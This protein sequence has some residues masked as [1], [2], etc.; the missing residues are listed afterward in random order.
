MTFSA[1]GP[2]HWR[3]Y[4]P[5]AVALWAIAAANAAGPVWAAILGGTDQDYAAAVAADPQGNVYVAGLTSSPDFLVTPGALQTKIGGSSDAFVAKF[6]PDGVLLWSTYLGGISDD[7]ATGVAVDAAGNVLV[8]GWTRSANFPILHAVQATLNNGASLNRQ[9]AFVAKLDPTGAKLLYATFLGGSGDDGAY[10]LALDAAGNAYVTGNVQ[11]SASFP[12]LKSLPDVS[13][14][15][16][17]KLDPQGAL[18]YTFLHPYG[19]ATG[20]AVDAA[21]SAYVAGTV[22]SNAPANS[23]TQT[24]GVPGDARAM[25]FKLS[26]DGSRRIYETTLGG[27][28]RADGMAVAVDRT[29]AALLAGTTSSAD[30]PLV[31]SLQSSLGARPLWKSTD[32][33]ATWVPLDDLPFANLQT[34]VVDPT[35]PNTLYAAAGDGGIFKSVDGGVTWKP[36]S[37]GIATTHMRAL[38]I[39][40]LHPQVLYAATGAGVSTGLV[41][42]T[43]DGGNNW[44]AVESMPSA[45][46]QQLLVDA[47]NPNNVYAVWDSFGTRTSDS[48]A[49]WS[50]LPFPGHILSLAL[51]PQ[52]SGNLYAYSASFSTPI[53]GVI[54]PYL[55]HS[56]DD[57]ANWVK[58]LSATPADPGV[59]VDASTNPSTVYVGLSSRSVDGGVTWS[60][61][62]PSPVATPFTSASAVAVDPNGALYA[63]VFTKGMFASRDRAQ[64]WTA[65]GSPVPPSAFHGNTINAIVPVGASGTLYAI[66]QNTQ[67]SGFVTKLSPDGSS[68]VYSTLLRGRAS[69]TPVVPNTFQPGVFTT[70]NWIDAIALDPAGN[71]VVAGGTRSNDFPMANAAQTSAGGRA[72]AFAA[73]I[74]ADGGR[75]TYSTYLGGSLDDGALAVAADSQGNVIA[76]GQTW[77]G[78]FPVTGGVHPPAGQPG[79]VFVAKLVPPAAP[80]IASVVDAASFQPGIEAG[81]WVTILGTNLSNTN[82]G[83]IWRTDEVVNGNLPTSLDGVGVTIDGKPAFVYYISPTQINVQAPSD[84]AL[85]PVNVVVTDHGASSAPATAQLQAVAPAFFQYPGINYVSASRLPDWT[86]VADPAAVPGTVAARP[87]DFVVLWGTGFGATNPTVPAGTTVSGAPATATA[88]TVMVGGVAA[89]VVS[90]VLTTG[91][92]GLYQVTIR[93]PPAAPAGPVA[94]QASVAGVR[95]ADGVNIFV[96]Q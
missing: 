83:R 42:K 76:A 49:T 6:T 22:S 26:A 11:S 41:Y 14:I 53:A 7:W 72:D 44:A 35:A 88:P 1:V 68:I 95:T 61:I 20:I 51:D 75:L 2:R 39:D 15:F 62:S 43:V 4:V 10:G 66:V 37:R 34:L 90:T 87:G 73:V 16:V 57:A 25:V 54:P 74:S 18:V 28:S 71:V 19:S 45:A 30:F 56:V 92:A 3:R 91:C 63:A 33:G 65:I 94:V 12:G 31:R 40:P 70:Q 59:T 32:S 58:I 29:G 38:G 69:M 9:D 47:R 89:E 50:G 82:P 85:G 27:S 5:L 60:S 80:A 36:A 78:D 93:I 46:V 55:F 67:T 24:F 48:G 64:T 86:A 77:S 79:A 52:T 21:G 81:S 84:A 23:A 17:A 13:G 8:T 96:A